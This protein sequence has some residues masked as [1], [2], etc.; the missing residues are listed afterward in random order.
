MTRSD[1]TE[2]VSPSQPSLLSTQNIDLGQEQDDV[3]LVEPCK[4]TQEELPVAE[5][6]GSDESP[7]DEFADD[8]MP[9]DNGDRHSFPMNPSDRQFS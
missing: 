8:A 4:P 3:M 9:V 1:M 6:D 2:T 5:D 7:L